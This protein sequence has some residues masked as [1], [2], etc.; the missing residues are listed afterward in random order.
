MA[1]KLKIM[2]AGSSLMTRNFLE[3]LI[4]ENDSYEAVRVCSDLD[5][6]IEWSKKIKADLIVIEAFC[7]SNPNCFE[8]VEQI[9]LNNKYSKVVMFTDLPEISFISRAKEAGCDSFWY[10]EDDATSLLEVINTTISSGS[11]FSLN[12][13]DVKIGC[14]SNKDFSSAEIGVLIK[15]CQCKTNQAIAEELKISVNTVKYH[16]KNMLAKSGYNNKYRLALE[17]V[18][19]RMI[20][21]LLYK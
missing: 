5:E 15:L 3:N 13:P 8:T 11:Y 4:N 7:N 10:V 19:K 14:A 20:I 17:V 18:D 9:K 2:L 6:V 16:I 21:P 12:T 1:N